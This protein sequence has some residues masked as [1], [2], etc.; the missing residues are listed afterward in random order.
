M[1]I[2]DLSGY[3]R[4]SF[5]FRNLKKYISFDEELDF[6]KAYVRIEQARFRDKL[7]VEYE[8]DHAE[9][10]QI[11]PLILQPLVEN[12]IRHGLRKS[13]EAGR[14][15]LRVKNQE[16]N[17]IIEVEDD[18][19]GMTSEQIDRILSEGGTTGSGVGLVN[20]RKRLK[21]L[22][23]TQLMIESNVGKGTKIT[24]ILPKRKDEV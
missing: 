5:D 17:Y 7:E 13:D 20:I 22:Y 21:V 9:E 14:I 19:A 10:L 18:G 11:P 15:V 23:G 4:H 16:S 8:V 2:L 1:L 3:L 24:L 6:I 12:A